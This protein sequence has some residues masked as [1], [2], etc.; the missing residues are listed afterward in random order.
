MDANHM[1]ELI[2]KMP[3][4]DERELA[5]ILTIARGKRWGRMYPSREMIGKARIQREVV[6]WR[7]NQF[8]HMVKRFKRL[9]GDYAKLHEDYVALQQ[10]GKTVQKDFW[11][12]E[13]KKGVS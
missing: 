2:I 10:N 9:R 8:V 6:L 12:E 1:T 13:S 5:K 4:I 11:T 7:C 3:K